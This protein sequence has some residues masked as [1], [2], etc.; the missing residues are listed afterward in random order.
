M[1]LTWNHYSFTPPLPGRKTKQALNRVIEGGAIR[2]N[3]LFHSFQE[4]NWASL[5]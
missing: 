1:V 3:N 5:I 4:F 2:K